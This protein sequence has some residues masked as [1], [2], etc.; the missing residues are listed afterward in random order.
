MEQPQQPHKTQ[1][2]KALKP[3]LERPFACDHCHYTY[4]YKKHLNE[5]I[6]MKHP[7]QDEQERPFAC[8]QC[9]NTYT[10]EGRLN[11]HIRK[12]HPGI[13]KIRQ[14]QEPHNAQR[15]WGYNE[16]TSSIRIWAIPNK[17]S[18]PP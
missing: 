8:D 4:A 12:K 9:G 1:N 15:I 14:P 6:R 10:S 16:L 11:E 18:A 7:Q 13:P 3:G 2:L 17:L 5:H